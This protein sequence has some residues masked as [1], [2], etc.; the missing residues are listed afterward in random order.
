MPTYPG[1]AYLRTVHNANFGSVALGETGETTVEVFNDG[2]LNCTITSVSLIDQPEGNP[3]DTAYFSFTAG[4]P[5]VPKTLVPAETWEISLTFAPTGSTGSRAIFVEFLQNGLISRLVVPAFG[6]AIGTSTKALTADPSS[7]MFPETKL[8][9]TSAEIEVILRSTGDTTVQVTGVTLPTGFSLSTGTFPQ[10]ILPGGT[11]T[12]GIEFS[13]PA[14]T[15]I[16]VDATVQ[17]DM[18]EGDLTINL[19]GQGSTISSAYT[20]AAS[21]PEVLVAL[22]DGAN[23][24]VKQFDHTNLDC[25]KDAYI[26]KVHLYPF[27]G[28]E[29]TPYPSTG[30][31]KQV[32]RAGLHYK[33]L[34]SVTAKAIISSEGRVDT[35]EDE[36]TFGTVGADEKIKWVWFDVQL[37]DELVRFRLERDADGGPLE[38]SDYVI[39]YEPKGEVVK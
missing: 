35:A 28:A 39:H 2:G 5:T 3:G 29:G 21:L 13:P 37:V 31:N 1:Y 9:E 25:E 14:A 26:E 18:T 24:T 30:S 8:G 19:Q 36:E 20:I 32:M 16:N 7:V 38:I 15:Y 27:Y 12:I 4:A 10:N 33:D 17:G 6:G 23:P 22:Y 11:Y 34:G